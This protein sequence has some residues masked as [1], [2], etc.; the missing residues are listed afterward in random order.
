VPKV[1]HC[2]LLAEQ[3]RQH[4]AVT[5]E[6]DMAWGEHEMLCDEKKDHFAKKNESNAGSKRKLAIITCESV[7]HAR[8][9]GHIIIP[10]CG[11][12]SA[13]THSHGRRCLRF[14]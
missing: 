14:E 2:A 4:R 8:V 11:S 6:A 9:P 7:S 1:Q 5:S 10:Q 3:S 13:R 12:D